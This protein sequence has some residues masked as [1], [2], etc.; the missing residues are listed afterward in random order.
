LHVD[1]QLSFQWR[2]NCILTG[3]QGGGAAGGTLNNCTLTGNYGDGAQGGLL[4]N[5]TLAGNYGRGARYGYLYNCTLVGN[6]NIGADSC[7]LY[8]CIVYYNPLANYNGGSQ[9]HCCT[10]PRFPS[11]FG[12]ITNAPLFIDFT[13]G[14][15]RL[16]SSS[17]CINSGNNTP[18]PGNNAYA[19]TATDLDGNPRIVSGTVDIGAY[20]Y[21]GAG[22]VISYAWLQHYG[23]PLD[24]SADDADP[25][26]DGMN[27]RQE[28]CCS[29]SPT[30]AQSALRLL[31]PSV[32]G[33]KTTI[34]WE[35]VAGVSYI[36]ERSTNPASSFTPLATGIIGKAGTTSY[37]DTNAVGAGPFFYRVGV[38]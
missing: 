20:E 38:K 9:D 32:T 26:H 36:L 17:P 4:Y 12:N 33:T 2:D 15:L 22:S 6:T 31:L 3:N 28:W 1:G 19:I 37:A 7:T 16:Q 29:T 25:D 18:S 34:K 5:C 35:S 30:N 24:G 21:Q 8:N 14:N 23:L 13:N 11:G 10:F 27:N